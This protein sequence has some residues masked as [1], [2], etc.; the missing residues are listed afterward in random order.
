MTVADTPHNDPGGAA[1][2]P[3][4]SRLSRLR[5]SRAERLRSREA[6]VWEGIVSSRRDSHE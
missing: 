6:A 1:M 5:G 3:R 2:P 4:L